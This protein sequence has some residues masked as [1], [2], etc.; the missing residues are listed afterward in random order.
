MG[1]IFNYAMGGIVDFLEV[2]I[3]FR[4]MMIF[5]EDAYVNDRL[6]YIAYAARLFISFALRFASVSPVISAGI[7]YGSIFFVS[8]CYVTIMSKRLIVSAFIYMCSFSSEAVVAVIVGISGFDAFGNTEH[9]SV[10]WNLIIEMIFWSISLIIRKFNN[11]N[12]KLKV[13]KSFVTFIIVIT[14]SMICLECM[15]FSQEKLDERIAGISLVCLISSVFM[16]MY[17]YDSLTIVIKEHMETAIAKKEKEYYH[18]QSE[19]LTEKYAELNK[20]RHDMKNRMIAI[21][22]MVNKKQYESVSRYT[23]EFVE[24][25]EFATPYCNTGNIALDS[26]VNY[27]L[28]K[29]TELGISVEID[30]VLPSNLPINEDDLVVIV[31]NLLDNAMDGTGMMEKAIDRFVQ[32]DFSYEK[33]SVWLCVKN[34]Y[35]GCLQRRGKSFFTS[36]KDKTMHGLG[37]QNV[38]EIVE[39]YNGLLE[40][41]TEDNLFVVDIVLHM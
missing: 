12:E 1:N 36:K 10:F 25:I 32:I 26:I 3:I 20:Y 38:R 23:E 35:N 19:M 8:L 7:S 30:I 2:Y 16:L 41:S 27:K 15:I 4:Y 5:F 29:M 24:K 6:A 13:P 21:Q 18:K 31:G 37:L 17:L 40:F 28:T 33:G 14:V 11:I 39:K 34:A 22:Q 9:I